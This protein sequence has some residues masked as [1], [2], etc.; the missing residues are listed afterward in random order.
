MSDVPTYVL[1]R[2]FDA[3]RELVWKT[4]TDPELLPRWYGPGVETIVHHLEVKPA[5]CGWTRCA[6]A[7]APTM[8]GSS[9][10]R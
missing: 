4:W 10:R 1:E 3:P 2:E 6:W 7:Q 8:S 9:T 5:G